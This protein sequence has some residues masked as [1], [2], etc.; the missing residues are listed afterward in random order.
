MN[1]QLPKLYLIPSASGAEARGENAVRLFRRGLA[2]CAENSWIV[3][4]ELFS[5]SLRSGL[6]DIATLNNLAVCHAALEGS[7]EAVALLRWAE[8]LNLY[9]GP[10]GGTAFANRAM[11]SVHVGRVEEAVEFAEAALSLNPG[12]A[13]WQAAHVAYTAA[14]KLALAEKYHQEKLL[15]ATH[16]SE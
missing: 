8:E 3:G 5:R 7:L 13:A 2:E 6:A 9:H 4:R 10:A 11:L 14:G 1:R 16:A 15:E 12:V